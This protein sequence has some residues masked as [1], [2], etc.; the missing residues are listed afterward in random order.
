M[1]VPK[2]MKVQT[3]QCRFFL[4]AADSAGDNDVEYSASFQYT[5]PVQMSERAP[6]MVAVVEKLCLVRLL[7]VWILWRQLLMLWKGRCWISLEYFEKMTSCNGLL[8][9]VCLS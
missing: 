9:A 5:V 3:R 1:T 8:C 6:D 2:R 4:A 7:L